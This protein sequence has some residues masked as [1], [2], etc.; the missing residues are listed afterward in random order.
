[1]RRFS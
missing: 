1:I